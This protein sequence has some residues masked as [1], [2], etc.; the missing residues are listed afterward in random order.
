MTA[1]RKILCECLESGLDFMVTDGGV[2][3]MSGESNKIRIRMP[4]ISR[5]RDA[6][7]SDILRA[8]YIAEI[9]F[10]K[11]GVGLP[12]ERQHP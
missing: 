8:K 4:A 5:Y 1:H 6:I 12:N 3:R 10:I 2:I 7:L 9:L 11:L